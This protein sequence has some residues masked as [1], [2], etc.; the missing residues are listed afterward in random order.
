[1]IW[2]RALIRRGLPLLALVTTAYPADQGWPSYG[3]DFGRTRYSAPNQI[4]SGNVSRLKVVWT[5]H[6]G[7]FQ[8]PGEMNKNAAFEA[9]RIWARVGRHLD[10]W[11]LRLEAMQSG[12][13]RPMVSRN[14]F[15]GELS[16]QLETPY[17]LER[18]PLET[19]A[20]LP[21]TPQ[22][23]GTISALNLN[24]GRMVWETPLGTMIPARK[25]GSI[26]VGGPITTAGDLVFT[27][28][29]I[30]PYLRAFN[31]GTGQGIWRG[32]IPAPTQATPMTYSVRGRQFV[33][34]CAGGHGLLGAPQSDAV[35][36]FALNEDPRANILADKSN[37]RL[38]R[39]V[40][41]MES[42]LARRE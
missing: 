30:E 21:C 9:E 10:A 33:V 5:Y 6:T 12:Q 32:S 8:Q 7:A 28:A 19:P 35:V 38:A 20:G 3:G 14:R 4:N 42:G 41:S 15:K 11:E 37:E 26:N 18:E 40:G 13:R 24:T 2:K 29:T 22:P 34:I 39:V 23:W 25:T 16:K 27:A 36:A 17:Y 31:A 1:M